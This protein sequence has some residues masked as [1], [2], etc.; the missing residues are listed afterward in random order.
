[1][2]D[3]VICDRCQKLFPSKEKCIVVV[4]FNATDPRRSGGNYHDLCEECRKGV[5]D[6]LDN[7]VASEHDP[8]GYELVETNDAQDPGKFSRV[9]EAEPEDG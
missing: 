8:V 1:M 9:I 5:I 2:A 4:D 6:F 7:K 3:I